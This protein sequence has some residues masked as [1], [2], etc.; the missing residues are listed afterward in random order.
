MLSRVEVFVC[1]FVCLDCSDMLMGQLMDWHSAPTG[2]GQ[3]LL[4]LLCSI[5]R[6]MTVRLLTT[7]L[8][9]PFFFCALIYALSPSSFQP[10][11]FFCLI[12]CFYLSWCAL[13][14][15]LL[16]SFP[17]SCLELCRNIFPIIDQWLQGK[18]QHQPR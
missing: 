8:P 11:F 4:G 7:H 3:R 2:G 6:R 17:F 12:I 13:V 5:C 10:N 14:Q 1:L 9:L 18:L 15:I 16:D